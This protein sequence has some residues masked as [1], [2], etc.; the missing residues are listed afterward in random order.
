[1][2]NFA[3]QVRDNRVTNQCIIE[4]LEEVDNT[5]D[6]SLNKAEDHIP[7][8]LDDITNRSKNTSYDA[9][10]G[11]PSLAPLARKDEHNEV[12]QTSKNLQEVTEKSKCHLQ[13]RTKDAIE[14]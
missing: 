14:N 5:F 12:N 1:M 8:T 11:M 10:E 2:S 4:P 6:Q 9:N 7:G 3:N 13:C